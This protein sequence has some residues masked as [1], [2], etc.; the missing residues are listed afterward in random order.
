LAME[1]IT[2]MVSCVLIVT[3]ATLSVCPPDVSAQNIFGETGLKPVSTVV[4]NSSFP[5]FKGIKIYPQEPFRFDFLMDT[6]E[7]SLRGEAEAIADKMNSDEIASSPSAPRNDTEILKLIK[8]FMASL[9]V[10]EGDLWVNLSPYEKDRIV[11]D[12]LGQT[13]MGIDLLAQDYVLK[14]LTASLMNPEGETGK[15]FWDN[16]YSKAYEQ[17]GTTNI[18]V[19]TFNKVWIVPN[20]VE[21]FQNGD[22]AYVTAASLKVMLEEDYL[23]NGERGMVDKNNPPTT[24]QSPTTDI[25]SIIRSVI[26]PVIEEEVNT[27]ASFANLRQIFYSMILAKWYEQHFKNSVLGMNYVDRNITEGIKYPVIARSPKDD[28]A[29]PD[30]INSDEIASSRER[31][32]FPGLNPMKSQS[33]FRGQKTLA[34]TVEGIYNQYVAAYKQGA[35]DFL[36]EEYDPETQSIIPKRYFAGGMSLTFNNAQLVENLHVPVGAMIEVAVDLA[37]L[38][39]NKEDF[40]RAKKAGLTKDFSTG[41]T[42]IGKSEFDAWYI[43]MIK[44][45][46]YMQNLI[47]TYGEG[48]ARICYS[49]SYLMD[50]LKNNLQGLAKLHQFLENHNGKILFEIAAGNTNIATKIAQA[51]RDFNVIATDEWATE[52]DDD[53]VLKYLQ[54]GLDF[55]HR[56]LSAQTSGAKNL[57][58]IRSSMEILQFVPDDS[59]DVILIVNPPKVVLWSLVV[60]SR[61]F[62]LAHK[63]KKDGRIIIKANEDVE[64]FLKLMEGDFS[65][66]KLEGYEYLGVDLHADSD[67][68]EDLFEGHVFEVFKNGYDDKA[69]MEE[70]QVS[71]FVP[72]T[73]LI[74]P[75]AILNS[76]YNIF[77][78]LDKIK[79]PSTMLLIGVGRGVTAMELALKY[80]QLKITA[81]NK[82]S[83]WWD[84]QILTNLMSK[85]GYKQEDITE[86]R[87][88]IELLFFD[89]ED[90]P[91][92]RIGHRVF[93]F[94]FFET[95]VQIYFEDNV[96]AIE[97]IF[98]EFVAENGIYGFTVN[99][100]F[101]SVESERKSSELAASQIISMA[102]ATVADLKT[103]INVDGYLYFKV[104]KK[105]GRLYLP[106]IKRTSVKMHIGTG[107]IEPNIFSY[108]KIKT[109]GT[110]NNFDLPIFTKTADEAMMAV[111]R[112]LEERA[113]TISS[114]TG[115]IDLNTLNMKTSG[116]ATRF[117][118]PASAGMTSGSDPAMMNQPIFGLT[119]KILHIGPVNAY[120]FLG[121]KVPDQ[122]D[123]EGHA[124]SETPDSYPELSFIREE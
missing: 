9:A 45:H 81:V 48:F 37:V 34:M 98:N 60:L 50:R 65:Y 22:T 69:M 77:D 58:A 49:T 82:D 8:Y 26:L 13:E 85:K 112:V 122:T 118:I 10:P 7:V 41:E 3:F 4:S 54:Y 83:L 75:S 63:L 72:E 14:Q 84:D 5:V 70:N 17:L 66:K 88:R 123:P 1:L 117:E 15:K 73:S 29:I 119:P 78:D 115:G 94:I 16:I 99:N 92:E 19:D 86:A 101:T 121:L 89:I 39:E 25:K 105:D 120:Q 52:L 109:P 87:T 18:P 28:E 71:K 38:E 104:Q 24:H 106:L 110:I 6:P 107:Y 103:S 12:A 62:K 20:Q 90:H 113:Q 61:E 91:R 30:K 108:Y 97:N 40:E 11:P 47:V 116:E 124:D 93:D 42:T 95:R 46:Q 51:N 114:H 74:R 67:Y 53:G 80:P 64:N 55:D 35:Y 96:R 33:D 2:R 44:R 21:V 56:Q 32:A 102:F 36:K 79:F 57:V 27:G 43:P 59:L 111:I 31:Q 100:I 76:A 68:A 23:G